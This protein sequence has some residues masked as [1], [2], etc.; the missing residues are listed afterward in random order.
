MPPPFALS[1]YGNNYFLNA[2][3]DLLHILT[4]SLTQGQDQGATL[5]QS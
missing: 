1:S 3:S 5:A 4:P 2:Q